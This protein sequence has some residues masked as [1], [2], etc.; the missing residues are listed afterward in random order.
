MVKDRIY[1]DTSVIGGCFDEEFSEYSERLFGEFIR[2][3]KI[4]AVSNIT[5]KELKSAPEKVSD[6][7]KEIPENNIEYINVSTGSDL[8]M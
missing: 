6:K 7:L 8:E 4:V 3:E 1:V 5:L 2:G